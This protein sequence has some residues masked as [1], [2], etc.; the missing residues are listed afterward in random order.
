MF[1]VPVAGDEDA[2]PRI[3]RR[4]VLALR[5]KAHRFLVPEQ[6]PANETAAQQPPEHLH[7]PGQSA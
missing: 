3:A 5:R 6:T 1:N 7:A 4:R 2:S